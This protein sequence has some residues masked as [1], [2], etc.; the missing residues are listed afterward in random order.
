MPNSY[1]CAVGDKLRQ[2]RNEKIVRKKRMKHAAL[3]KRHQYARTNKKRWPTGHWEVAIALRLLKIPY[4]REVVIPLLGSTFFQ[5]DFFLWK[6]R[7]FLE[8]DGAGHNKSDDARRERIIL[9]IPEFS[10]C[11][12]VR[13]VADAARSSIGLFALS[14]FAS[15]ENDTWQVWGDISAAIGESPTQV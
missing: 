1:W 5:V 2:E 6:S 14:E 7:V 13:L 4:S 15:P 8:I 3:M 12:F 11:R 10:D 9:S